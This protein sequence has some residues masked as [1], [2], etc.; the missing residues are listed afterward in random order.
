VAAANDVD[1]IAA[2]VYNTGILADPS[3]GAKYDYRPAT[4]D[5]LDRARGLQ[6]RCAE[7]GVRLAAAAIRFPL[8]HEAVAGVVVGARTADEVRQFAADADAAIPPELWAELDG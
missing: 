4:A 3:E 2:G 1:V 6:S 7:Q 5:E 8:R